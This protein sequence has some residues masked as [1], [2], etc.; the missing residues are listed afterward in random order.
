[1]STFTLIATDA[2]QTKFEVPVIGWDKPAYMEYQG[3]IR[4][5]KFLAI[6]FFVDNIHNGYDA[7][8]WEKPVII[9]KIAGIGNKDFTAKNTHGEIPFDYAETPTDLMERTFRKP[10]KYDIESWLGLCLKKPFTGKIKSVPN[11]TGWY[12]A[13]FRWGGVRPVEAMVEIPHYVYYSKAEGFHFNEPASVP[14]GTYATEQ[15]CKDANHVTVIEF[16][17]EDL[18]T[19]DVHVYASRTITVKATDKDNAVKMAEEELDA[20]PLEKDDID[21]I[22][23]LP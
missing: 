12:A 9:V 3:A 14:E 23:T 4:A 13:R 8:H 22:T 19:F 18:K 1:M 17:E 5:F 11:G 7:L 6:R 15:A 10:D 2:Y 21:V 20:N 16:E